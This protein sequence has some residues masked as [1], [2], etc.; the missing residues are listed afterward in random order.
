MSQW[1]GR[2]GQPLAVRAL[3]RFGP[4]VATAVLLAMPSLPGGRPASHAPGAAPTHKASAA[5]SHRASGRPAGTGGA[6]AAAGRGPATV[7]TG[8]TMNNGPARARPSARHHR[9]GHVIRP[10]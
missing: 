8:A 1:A 5:A 9:P 3:W 10:D 2:K 4:A 6:R 7:S